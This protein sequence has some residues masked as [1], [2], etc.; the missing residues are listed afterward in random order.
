MTMEIILLIIVV[1][2]F[3][4][5]LFKDMSFGDEREKM[6]LK[7]M[8][9]DLTEYQLAVE[10]EAKDTPEPI[11]DERVPLEEVSAEELL[12]AIDKS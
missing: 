2:Q 3:A 4:Y 12:K 1:L 7:L 11:V 5:I 9:R 10:P 6:L 8:S